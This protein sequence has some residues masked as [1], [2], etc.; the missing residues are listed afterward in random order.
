MALMKM[1][2]VEMH[3][4]GDPSVLTVEQTNI[5][6]ATNGEVVIEI[7]AA[8]INRPD[9]LQRQGHYPPPPGA[10]PILGLEVSGIITEC[11]ENT[12]RF[13]VGDKVCALLGGGGYAEYVSVPE[14]QCLPIPDGLSMIEAAALPETFFTVWTNVFEDGHLSKGESILIHGGT[15]GIGTTAI[16]LAS[17]MGAKVFT[18]V[19]KPASAD[20]CKKLGADEV[21]LYKESDFVE[22]I[23]KMTEGLGVNVILDII[24][25]KYFQKNLDSLSYQGRLIQLAT[26][27]GSK[28]SL[29]LAYMMKKR[30]SMTGSM[31]RPRSTAEKSRIARELEEKIWPMLSKGTLKPLIDKTF[32]LEQASE[33]H[34]LMESSQHTGKIVLSVKA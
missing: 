12:A 32:P 8:G 33:A 30:I 23:K 24:G 22:E 21:I 17:E 34:A 10:S 28:V 14:G 31:L 29:D 2:Y 16:Q 1:K 3:K 15:G 19:G 25:E 18:T 20:I 11:G 5:P 6:S 4:G 9:C 27:S 13:K 7:H 26:L